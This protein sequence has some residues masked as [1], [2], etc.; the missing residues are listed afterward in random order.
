M[1]HAH[2][3]PTAIPEIL[4]AEGH[5]LSTDRIGLETTVIN[6]AV[7][8]RTE[9]IPVQLAWD[10]AL[11]WLILVDGVS[12]CVYTSPSSLDHVHNICH[13]RYVCRVLRLL[14]VSHTW[15]L[16]W[17]TWLLHRHTWLLH[18]HT[19]LLHRHPWLL[20]WHPWLLHW[21]S[22]L[23]HRHPWLLH[24]HTWLLHRHPW[25]LHRHP[26][27]LHSRVWVHLWLDLHP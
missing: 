12:I 17:H 21:H 20:H 19:W 8:S 25:L 1:A 14:V 13:I 18:W 24:R 9:R 16:H 15:L 6:L 11:L 10:D 26:W 23:L 4:A 2:L 3:P 5:R 7:L 22:W 27:L